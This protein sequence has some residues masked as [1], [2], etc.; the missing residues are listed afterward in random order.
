MRIVEMKKQNK[1]TQTKNPTK[2]GKKKEQKKNQ[3]QKRKERFG[4]ASFDDS[5]MS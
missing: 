2:E 4:Q 3:I 1:T 5:A